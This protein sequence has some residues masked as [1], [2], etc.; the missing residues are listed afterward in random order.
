MEVHLLGDE[1]DE[2]TM[3]NFFCRRSDGKHRHSEEEPR[4]RVCVPERVY[5]CGEGLGERCP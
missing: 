4:T 5:G 3:Q 2:S 1:A